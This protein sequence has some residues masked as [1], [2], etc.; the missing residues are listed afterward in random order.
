M[1]GFGRLAAL[2]RILP[3]HSVLPFGFVSTRKPMSLRMSA[4]GPGGKDRPLIA[5]PAGRGEA[6]PG[7]QDG[8]RA[9]ASATTMATLPRCRRRGRQAAGLS[10]A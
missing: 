9:T 5:N 2:G 10:E 7:S 6:D 3:G 4:A 1:V 8:C